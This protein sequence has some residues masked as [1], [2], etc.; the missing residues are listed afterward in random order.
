M[1]FSWNLQ[2]DY[3]L[4]IVTKSNVKV[5]KDKDRMKRESEGREWDVNDCVESIG[6]KKRRRRSSDRNK[7]IRSSKSIDAYECRVTSIGWRTRG[8]CPAE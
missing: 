6:R 4:S 8:K 2:I 3:H 7:K 1:E 5:E